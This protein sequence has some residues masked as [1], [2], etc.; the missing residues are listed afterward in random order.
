MSALR[1]SI[2]TTFLKNCHRGKGIMTTTFLKNEVIGKQEHAVKAFAP[3]NPQL[4][5]S[6]FMELT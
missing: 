6:N 2:Y 1:A 3:T 4:W 5:Q